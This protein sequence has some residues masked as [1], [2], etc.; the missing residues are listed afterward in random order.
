MFLLFYLS[1][2]FTTTTGH[3]A[4]NMLYLGGDRLAVNTTHLDVD[5]RHS[6]VPKTC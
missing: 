3:K 6:V 2:S 5:H 1:L 4:E